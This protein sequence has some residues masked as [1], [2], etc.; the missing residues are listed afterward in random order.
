MLLEKIVN[1]Q[2]EL[3]MRDTQFAR[4]LGLPRS[5]WGLTKA[6]RIPLGPRVALAAK[7]A[8]PELTMDVAF[9]LVSDANPIA[10]RV[11]RI[12]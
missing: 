1:K 6:G 8:F 4:K 11:R 10:K 2:S 12:A 7:E 9:F 5:T 3:G